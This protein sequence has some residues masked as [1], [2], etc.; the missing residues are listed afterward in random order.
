MLKRWQKTRRGG[1]FFD[2]GAGLGPIFARLRP[3]GTLSWP[4]WA[5]G[6]RSSPAVLGVVPLGG[7]LVWLFSCVF[8]E[9]ERVDHEGVAEQVEPLAAV[10][11]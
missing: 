3:D 5:L 6:A 10:A 11:D 9:G 8:G 4:G 2:G 7:E 1:E